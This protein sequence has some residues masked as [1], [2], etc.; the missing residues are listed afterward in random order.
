MIAG[1]KSG[2][3]PRQPG[4]AT[5]LVSDAPFPGTAD[6]G[7]AWTMPSNSGREAVTFIL[8]GVGSDG[9]LVCEVAIDSDFFALGRSSLGPIVPHLRLRLCQA[10]VDMEGLRAL[11]ADLRQWEVDRTP[12]RRQIS[13]DG[14]P[15][16]MVELGPR[17]D[18]ISSQEQPVF[19]VRYENTL[20][21]IEHGFVVDQSCVAIAVESLAR[22]V[23]AG[24][25]TGG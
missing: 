2:D 12:V 1:T 10:V 6:S 16:L 15:P 9:G 11:L 3:Q 14:V 21:H 24:G 17:D 7:L 19:T 23:G 4:P 8:R 13:A 18:V 25:A 20:T 22:I 5:P